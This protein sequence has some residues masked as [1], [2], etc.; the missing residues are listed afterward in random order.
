MFINKLKRGYPV[1]RRLSATVISLRNI[2]SLSLQNKDK[3]PK[4]FFFFLRAEYQ[5]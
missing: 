5:T 4:L 2:F 3:K 1:W